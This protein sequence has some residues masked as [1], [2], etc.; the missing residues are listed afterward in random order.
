MLLLMMLS[1]EKLMADDGA[2]VLLPLLLQSALSGTQ[3]DT[4]DLLSGLLTGKPGAG[5]ARQPADMNTL[6]MQLLYRQVTGKPWPGAMRPGELGMSETMPTTPGKSAMSRPSVQLSV[7]GLGLSSILQAL[8]I[9][10]TPFGM[11]QY[12][13]DIGTLA[14]LVP[15]TTGAL[16][17]TGG[18]GALA[19]LG[20]SLLSGFRRQPA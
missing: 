11:G 10:G 18:F 3:M 8:G 4:S 14:T 15:I 5:A 6:L 17:A 13:T 19:N 7:A 1:K 9:V 12:P 20:L 16:G 2:K